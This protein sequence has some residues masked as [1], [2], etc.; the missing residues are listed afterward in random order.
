MVSRY[1]LNSNR[2]DE[3]G[4]SKNINSNIYKGVQNGTIIHRLH[5]TKKGDRLDRIAF[6]EYKDAKLWWIIAAASGIGWWLQV[7]EGI[8][9]KI[10]TDLSQIER[11][12]EI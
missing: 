4:T 3:F 9:L 6:N 11:L 10:P 1:T 2:F 5:I 8:E 7:T 12:S